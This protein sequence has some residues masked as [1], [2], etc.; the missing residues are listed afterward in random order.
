[1]DSIIIF[2]KGNGRNPGSCVC[3]DNISFCREETNPYVNYSTEYI[4]I[5]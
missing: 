3:G 1:M 4:I 5:L 2:I